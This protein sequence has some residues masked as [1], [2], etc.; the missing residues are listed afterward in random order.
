MAA[1]ETDETVHPEDPGA[2]VQAPV[3]AKDEA[4]HGVFIDGCA[5]VLA[6]GVP[7]QLREFLFDKLRDLA[8]GD[9]NVPVPLDAFELGGRSFGADAY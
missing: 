3:D 8:V 9:I 2:S 7:S 4:S 6:T 5:Q 1:S